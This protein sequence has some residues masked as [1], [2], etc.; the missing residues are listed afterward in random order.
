MTVQIEQI[1][2][3]KDDF[4]SEG[5]ILNVRS[6]GVSLSW[7]ELIL[8][9]KEDA[10]LKPELQRNYIWDKVEASWFVESLLLGLPVPSIFLAE[11]DDA[12]FLIVD[13]YQRIMT[14]YDFVE[15]GIF[16]GDGSTFSLSNSEKIHSRW[17]KK[18]FNQLSDDEQRRILT[19]TVHAI[20]FSAG[21]PDAKH[22]YP[23]GDTS[24][25]Q[26]FER[27]NTTGRSLT[28]QEIRN[29]I[30]QGEFN[31]LLI[32]L[33]NYPSW[34]DGY[35]NGLANKRMSDIEYILRFFALSSKYI[36]IKT[37]GQISLKKFLNQ[38]MDSDES[39]SPKILKEREKLFKETI[40]FINKNLGNTAF[41]N[42]STQDPS[43]LLKRFHP[44][45]FDSISIATA[46]VIKNNIAINPKK[47][48][49]KRLNLLRDEQYQEYIYQRT[50][51]FEHINGR[52]RLAAQYL[53]DVDYE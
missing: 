43:E 40:D 29:C 41:F 49:E 15:R 24:L 22:G 10:L 27:I 28:A 17:R 48:E 18:T 38:Y 45:I 12:K 1:P 31:T 11:R 13:G 23:D 33:N 16:G 35:W 50:T 4:Y 37:S 47:L 53:Y 7:R 14:V 19:R 2:D 21:D 46:H 20:I 44:T 51:R 42:L 30:Y 5:K 36:R 9:Y 52:I 34:Q 26:I 25:Y 32:N 6:Y 8:R 39:K 3:E